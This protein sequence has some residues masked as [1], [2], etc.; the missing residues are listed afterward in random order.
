VI[1]VVDEGRSISSKDQAF[2][3]DFAPLAEHIYRLPH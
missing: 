2:T 1:E 3:D